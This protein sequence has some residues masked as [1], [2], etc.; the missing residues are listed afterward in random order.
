MIEHWQSIDDSTLA[1]RSIMIRNLKDT[2]VLEKILLAL[3][4]GEWYYI[5]QVSD[6]NNALPIRFKI[7]FLNGTEFIAENRAHDFPQRIS[8]R[9]KDKFLFASIEGYNKGKYNKQNF[10]YQLE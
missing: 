7:I 3:R 8:Y 4:N 9:R 10:D 2:L 6:Q 1:G 5:P